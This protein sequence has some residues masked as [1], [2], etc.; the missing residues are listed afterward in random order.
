[1]YFIVKLDIGALPVNVKN[2][3]NFHFKSETSMKMQVYVY[4]G[5][6][7]FFFCFPL[8]TAILQTQLEQVK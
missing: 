6:F 3:A 8:H 7:G 1:M 2:E 5:Q 4:F